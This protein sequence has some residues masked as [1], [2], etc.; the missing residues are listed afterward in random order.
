MLVRQRLS[1]GTTPAS[2]GDSMDCRKVIGH[3]TCTTV[4]DKIDSNTTYRTK[5]VVQK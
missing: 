4:G 5:M 1:S 3:I 2:V